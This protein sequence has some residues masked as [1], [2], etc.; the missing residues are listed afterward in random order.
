MIEALG[1]VNRLLRHCGTKLSGSKVDALG[2]M[3]N[4]LKEKKTRK[5]ENFSK[6]VGGVGMI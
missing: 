2:I 6:K 5:D 4:V 1:V 3:V